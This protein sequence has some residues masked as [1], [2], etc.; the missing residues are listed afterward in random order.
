MRSI[1]ELDVV[2]KAKEKKEKKNNLSFWQKMTV[3]V[4]TFTDSD[5]TE[6]WG[7]FKEGVS[8]AFHA[9]LSWL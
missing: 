8:Q 1:N 9:V 5:K 3:F 2:G 4:G 6:R 7:G